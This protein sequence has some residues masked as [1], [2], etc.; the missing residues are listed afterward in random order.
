MKILDF[1]SLRQIYDHDCGANA[2]QGI[3]A[4]YG[5]E[6]NEETVM[7]YAKTNKKDGTSSTNICRTLK[8]FKLK[9]KAKSMDI[10]EVK[11]FIDKKVPVLIVLQAWKEKNNDYE[12]EYKHGHWVVAIGYDKN[13]IIF[14]DPGSFNR[15]FLKKRELIIR[16]HD[17]INGQKFINHGIAVYGKKPV[18]NAKNIV[19]MD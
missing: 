19:H 1:P 14:E 15:T 6:L 9:Y 3:L 16:W 7:K 18:Y 12:N 10:N 11:D 8:K 5:I 17:K 2:L 13:R 4:Y